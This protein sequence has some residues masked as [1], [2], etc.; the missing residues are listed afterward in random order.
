MR[1]FIDSDIYYRNASFS[2]HPASYTAVRAANIVQTR[3]SM[4]S[5]VCTRKWACMENKQ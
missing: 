3:V 5:N 2:G 4:R 1:L